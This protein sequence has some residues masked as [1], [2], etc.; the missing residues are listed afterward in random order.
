M[1]RGRSIFI[2]FLLLI[3]GAFLYLALH[4]DMLKVDTEW[5]GAVAVFAFT[6]GFIN[7]MRE[8]FHVKRK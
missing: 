6:I 2:S 5:G 3:T 4:D 8:L 7:F 1:S